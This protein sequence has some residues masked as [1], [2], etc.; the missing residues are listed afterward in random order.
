MK[1]K[2]GKL[3]HD[4]R[5][6]ALRLEATRL[7]EDSA[8]LNNWMASYASIRWMASYASIRKAYKANKGSIRIEETLGSTGKKTGVAIWSIFYRPGDYIVPKGVG[9]LGVIGCRKFTTRT[10]NI[11]LKAA[12]VVKATTKKKAKVFAAKAAR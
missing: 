5:G 10:F 12:G 11:I 1:T 7:I 4:Y 9:P 2:T 3:I 8:S 6:E